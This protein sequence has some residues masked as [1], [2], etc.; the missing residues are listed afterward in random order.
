MTS[1]V[2]ISAGDSPTSKTRA[3]AAA[4]LELH[5]GGELVELLSLSAEGL[6]GRHDDAAVAAA[7]DA[8]IAADVLLVAS[9]VY[10]A[11]YTGALKAFFDRFPPDSL[12]STVTVLA[13]TAIAPAHF[14]SLD[15]GMRPLVT[16]LGGWAS[17]SVVY[18][19]GDDF[20]DGVP[21]ADLRSRLGA[22]L[23]EAS[24]VA[25]ALRRP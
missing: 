9:P 12:R 6:L 24:T 1:L 15:T 19:V 7:V 21:G 5:G 8:A 17:P 13:A 16:S 11:T 22:A 23:A 4:G 20:V 2:A 10:R 14:L 25:D 3:L 18:A